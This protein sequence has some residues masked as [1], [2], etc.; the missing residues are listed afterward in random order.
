MASAGGSSQSHHVNVDSAPGDPIGENDH[1]DPRYPLWRHVKK[2]QPNGRGGGNAK[3]ECLFCEK[4]IPGS[5]TRVRAHLLKIPNQGVETCRK[6]TVP[7]L[8]QLHR[9]VAEADAIVNG[10]QPNNIPLPTQ[11]GSAG[12]RVS[13]QA[14]RKKQTGIAESFHAELRQQ[15]DALIARMFYSGGMHFRFLQL[16]ICILKLST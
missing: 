2:I 14:K 15:A 8:E 9:E 10:R 13:K 16:Y 11:T 1:A 6:V 12:A 7:I 5:Y 4:I 3:S